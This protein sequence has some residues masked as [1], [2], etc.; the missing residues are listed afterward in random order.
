MLVDEEEY[1]E[2]LI[3]RIYMCVCMR[4]EYVGQIGSQRRDIHVC[5][6]VNIYI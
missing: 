1:I 4:K 5:L 2:E 3:M 6:C